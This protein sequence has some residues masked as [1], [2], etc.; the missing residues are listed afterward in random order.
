MK[1]PLI[2]ALVA[3]LVACK[4]TIPGQDPV[5]ERFPEVSGED[6]NG[7]AVA[8]LDPAE[9]RILLVGYEQRTQFD[10]D[11]WILGL[12]QTGTPA[13]LVEVPTI[14]GLLPGMAAGYIDDGMRGG[15]PP[16][17]WA[18]VVTLYGSDASAV[19][20]FTGNELGNNARVLL[21]DAN[22]RVAWFHDRGY[23]ATLV[24]DLDRAFRE[25]VEAGGVMATTPP[26]PS[27]A[28]P[29]QLALSP[30][31]S[32][33][34]PT[35]LQPNLLE[36][37]PDPAAGPLLFDFMTAGREGDWVTVDDRVMGGRSRSGLALGPRGGAAFQ[38]SLVLEGGGFA[39]VRS[40]PRAPV[41]LTASSAI[42][43]LVRGDGRTY[44]LR[45]RDRSTF[46]GIAWKAEFTP[47]HGHWQVVRIPLELFEPTFRGR[48]VRNA[49]PLELDSIKTF[50]L[51]LAGGGGGDFRLDLRWIRAAP[52]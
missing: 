38:G 4:A 6:L 18:A 41:D 21:L 44:Q 10:I 32:P 33:R 20:A 39:S 1:T 19:A 7:T 26:E 48:L 43:L 24:L 50:G 23:S 52:R 12:Q 28:A 42:E 45:L 2:L 5:G 9:P 22:D 31:A 11:R 8:L 37:A 34:A 35:M 47:K 30:E 14:P 51:L 16:E 3:S 15:I 46:D 29:V 25:L 13:P 40:V 36:T 17:D 27:A 49:E